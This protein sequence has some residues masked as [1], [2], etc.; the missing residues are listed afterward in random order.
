SSA[1]I[2][3][4]KQHAERSRDLKRKASILSVQSTQLGK[5]HQ[6]ASIEFLQ[7]R[8]DLLKSHAEEYTTL[9]EG[10]KAGRA[11]KALT[12]QEFVDLTDSCYNKRAKLAAEELVL[13]RDRDRIV[14][15]LEAKERP[16]FEG[17]YTALFTQIFKH[18]EGPA[19]WERRKNYY[20]KDERDKY[21]NE[22]SWRRDVRKHYNAVDPDDAEQLWCPILQEYAAKRYRKTAHIVPHSLGY[23]LVGYIFGDPDKGREYLWELKNAMIMS[24]S[25]EEGFDRGFF[26][27]LPLESKPGE[28]SRWQFYLLA[29]DKAKKQVGETGVKWGQLHERELVWKND[30]RP[31]HRYLYYHFVAN[32]LRY[33]RYEKPGWEK[34]LSTLPNG[35]LWATPGAYL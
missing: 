33:Q 26:V 28:P 8:R 16:D 2:V 24:S 6:K 30:K 19:D 13:D 21:R 29:S 23:P 31:G 25:L 4:H 9:L 10:Y 5:L 20:E 32:M 27:L 15:V 35:T 1:Q 11:N 34:Y 18:E 22:T 12:E 17:A 14:Q 3:A 7:T